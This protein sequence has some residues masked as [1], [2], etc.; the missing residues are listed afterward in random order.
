[1]WKNGGAGVMYK[2]QTTNDNIPQHL[3]HPSQRYSNKHYSRN[4]ILAAI[5]LQQP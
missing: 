5:L 4:K 3:Q 1:M 2:K